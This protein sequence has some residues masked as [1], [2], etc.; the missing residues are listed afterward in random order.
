MVWRLPDTAPP[1][2]ATDLEPITFSEQTILVNLPSDSAGAGGMVAADVDGDQ[3]PEVIVTRAGWIG[4]YSLTKG[5]LWE[6]SADLRLTEQAES[7]GLPGLHGA[8]VQVAD[9]DQDGQSEG[10]RN[11]AKSG[12]TER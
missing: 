7:Q 2:I 9:V 3:Q 5:K 1:A 8:G 6:V 10:L 4:A 11:E 12:L